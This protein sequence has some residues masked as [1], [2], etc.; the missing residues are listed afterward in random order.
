[1]QEVEGARELAVRLVWS[2]CAP[3]ERGAYG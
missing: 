2:D 3:H 1:V